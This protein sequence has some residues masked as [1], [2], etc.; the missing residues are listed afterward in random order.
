MLLEVA[1][2][3][4]ADV[5]MN[6]GSTF[7]TLRQ[8]IREAHGGYLEFPNVAG[9]AEGRESQ[10]KGGCQWTREGDAVYHRL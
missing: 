10:G 9:L 2:G 8:H 6:F 4:F 3:D 7:L 1:K 5:K